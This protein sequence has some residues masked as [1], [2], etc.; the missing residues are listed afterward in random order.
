MKQEEV[1]FDYLPRN[2]KDYDCLAKELNGLQLRALCK[3]CPNRVY[4]VSFHPDQCKSLDVVDKHGQGASVFLP[5]RRVKKEVNELEE[6][7]KED[8]P[9]YVEG[10]S[11]VVLLHPDPCPQ[12]ARL[13]HPS[14]SKQP[15][16][17][18]HKI[19]ME[20]VNCQALSPAN[21]ILF[22]AFDFANHGRDLWA[23][24]TAG[25]LV[26]RDLR[27]PKSSARLWTASKKKIGC[28]SICPNS[29]DRLAVTAGLN[30]EIQ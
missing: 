13:A 8:W 24:D 14:P 18:H 29:G 25:R 5:A 30:Q 22:S 23:S 15:A 19:S 3:G 4:S 16:S 20:I 1:N 28:L 9:E 12:L 27:Q 21:A 10:V 26:H 6:E 2:N 11:S 17:A 7:D